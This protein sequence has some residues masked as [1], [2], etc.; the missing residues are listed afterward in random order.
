[1]LLNFPA[2]ARLHFIDKYMRN[3][4]LN[5]H[6]WKLM[7]QIGPTFFKQKFS[8]SFYPIHFKS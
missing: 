1:M 5:M 4:N 6:A 2:N 7:F 8:A 3:K